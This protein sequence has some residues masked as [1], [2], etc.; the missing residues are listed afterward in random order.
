LKFFQTGTNT[1]RKLALPP[2]LQFRFAPD[3]TQAVVA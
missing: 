1:T 3:N 2:L